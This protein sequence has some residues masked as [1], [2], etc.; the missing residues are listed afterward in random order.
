MQDVSGDPLMLRLSENP[1][2]SLDIF[3]QSH[4]H[5]IWVL[6]QSQGDKHRYTLVHL[7]VSILPRIVRI[8][9]CYHVIIQRQP[10]EVYIMTNN[11]QRLSI[12]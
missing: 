1:Q 2:A 10:K 12:A 3:W 9:R 6:H 7:E 11:R 8:E 5:P 4:H